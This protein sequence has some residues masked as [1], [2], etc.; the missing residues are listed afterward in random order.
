MC[1]PLMFIGQ[2]NIGVQLAIVPGDVVGGLEPS[3]KVSLA[4]LELLMLRMQAQCVC[5]LLFDFKG[6]I[7]AFA[8]VL[9][10]FEALIQSF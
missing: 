3:F 7:C 4:S 6:S 8:Y 5:V 1:V 9:L 10:F 2:S